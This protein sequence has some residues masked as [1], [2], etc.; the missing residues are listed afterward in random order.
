MHWS[1]Q[2]MLVLWKAKWCM[3]FMSAS[4]SQICFSFKNNKLC[5]WCE[6]HCKL[7]NEIKCVYYYKIQQVWSVHVSGAAHYCCKVS[8]ARY[9]KVHNAHPMGLAKKVWCSDVW[10]L[11][12]LLLVTLTACLN[13]K[14][15]QSNPLFH[16]LFMSEQSAR[17]PV[18]R[19]IV[20]H[21]LNLALDLWSLQAV[22]KTQALETTSILSALHSMLCSCPFTHSTSKL[23]VPTALTISLRLASLCHSN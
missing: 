6:S 20:K 23:N 4:R 13:F 16:E 18:F 19:F 10:I 15:H 11:G 7:N 5:P 21:K 12:V 2:N 14:K 1:C 8:S 9:N 22:I 3:H 17:M